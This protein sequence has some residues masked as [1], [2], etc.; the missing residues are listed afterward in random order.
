MAASWF[1]RIPV[2]IYHVHGL[3]LLTAGGWKRILLR[4][5]DLIAGRLAHRMICVCPSL[6]Q[7]A[8][9]ERLFTEER[10]RVLARGAINGLDS[11]VKFNPAALEPTLVGRHVHHWAFPQMLVCSV[12]SGGSSALKGS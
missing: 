7:A 12:I 3:P 4:C 2:R 5:C 8:L 9:D 10:T 6:R 1:A 11:A